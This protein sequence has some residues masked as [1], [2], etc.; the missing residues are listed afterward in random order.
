MG[1]R[2]TVDGIRMHSGCV[3]KEMKNSVCVRGGG[4]LIG[5]P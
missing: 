3:L 4:G 5:L 1:Q 2:A